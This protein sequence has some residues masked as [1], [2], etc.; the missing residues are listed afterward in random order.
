MKKD[1]NEI[2]KLRNLLITPNH[3][4][5]H[6]CSTPNCSC[7][8]CENCWIKV[9]HKGKDWDTIT[10][11]D[12]PTIYDKFVC[13]YCRNVDWKDYMNN[14]LHELRF[15]ILTNEEIISDLFHL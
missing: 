8:I 15:K 11:N 9:T 14:V 6:V 5:T 10:E 3:N 7:I 13:P 1:N 12:M 4:T 2:M